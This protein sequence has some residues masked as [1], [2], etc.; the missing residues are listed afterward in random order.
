MVIKERNLPIRIEMDRA[1]LRRLPKN[2]S[3][4]PK[5]EEDLARRMAGYRGEQSLDFPLNKLP[6]KDYMI[7]HDVRLLNNNYYFQIDTLLISPYYALI[8]EVK[9]ISGTLHFDNDFHQL[10]RTAN[11]KEEG[12]PNPLLQAR[13]QRDEFK[14]WLADHKFYEIPVEYLVVISNPSTVIKRGPGNSQWLKKVVHSA[15]LLDKMAELKGRYTQQQICNKSMRK[16]SRLILQKHSFQRI[17]ILKSY[18]INQ[19]DVLT[20][21]Q[22]PSC[23]FLPMIYETRKWFCP[24]CHNHLPDAHVQAINDYFLL[25]N[26]TATNQQIC[27][28]L[29]LNS[30]HITKRLLTNLAI[31]HSG[32]GKARVYYSPFMK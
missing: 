17:E 12:F 25:I 30:R 24:S 16:I 23:F 14:I 6:H 21:V 22:C 18:D 8:L 31:P 7:F 26:S 29:H 15:E 11:E 5:I 4:R 19:R 1:L 9:N 28:F 10:I 27:S 2:H 3:K 13:Q 20:G 32:T